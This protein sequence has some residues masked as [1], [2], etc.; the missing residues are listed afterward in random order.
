M[1]VMFDLP[2]ADA[3][4][5]TQKQAIGDRHRDCTPFY[6]RKSKYNLT[7]NQTDAGADH[8]A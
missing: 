5:E 1:Q 4:Y 7:S 3:Y 8:T 6:F 2:V